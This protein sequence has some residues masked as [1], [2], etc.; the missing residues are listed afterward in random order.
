M[1]R[2]RK[3]IGLRNAVKLAREY[4]EELPAAMIILLRHIVAHQ[5]FDFSLVAVYENGNV[6]SELYCGMFDE[7]YEVL[8]AGVLLCR[9]LGFANQC[10]FYDH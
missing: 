3:K 8:T 6:A 5:V 4:H 9:I 10:S 7:V 2:N 1:T